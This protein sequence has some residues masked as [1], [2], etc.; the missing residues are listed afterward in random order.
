[1]KLRKTGFIRVMGAAL[2]LAIGVPAAF[3]MK[4]AGNVIRGT[5]TATSN[6]DTLSLDGHQ[7]RIKSGSPA[8]EAGRKCPKGTVVDVL[9]NGPPNTAASEAIGLVCHTAR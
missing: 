6:G 8:V 2:V 9:L 7:Y 5:L 4:P 3:A 1:L